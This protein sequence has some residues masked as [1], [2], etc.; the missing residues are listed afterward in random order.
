MA[1]P[2]KKNT[3]EPET[4]HPRNPHAG[5]YDF[6]ALRQ[7]C[8]EL[9]RHLRPNPAGDHTIDFADRQAVVCLNRAL[10]AHHY[11]VL[12]WQIPPGYL[13]PPIPGRADAI[14]HLA[15]LLATGEDGDVPT[16]KKVNVLDIGTG[17]NCIYP[18]IGSRS[19]GW[20]FVGTD[21]DPIAIKTARA[22]VAANPGLTKLVK[23]VQQKDPSSIFRGVIHKAD[24]FDLTMCNPPFHS[25]IEEAHA[26]TRRKVKNLGGKNFTN[27]SAQSN[28]GGQNTE[29]WCPGGELQFVTGMIRESVEFAAQ[30]HWFTCLI[31][32]SENLPPL[33]KLLAQV[34]AKRT[35]VIN[36]SHGQKRTRLIAWSF[37]KP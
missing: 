16:G 31:S 37:Q 5:R 21:I 4:F 23:I 6:A 9:E 2:N 29:L 30:V 26:G 12:H 19:Y 7:S 1:S 28:F 15:D 32:K 8:P 35:E 22:I 20:S 13:C 11:Q 27:I 3:V 14:H 18:I 17:A 34:N 33:K 10:L 24:H 36:M 25:S